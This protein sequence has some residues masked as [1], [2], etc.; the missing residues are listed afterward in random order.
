MIETEIKRNINEIFFSKLF[1]LLITRN[2][3]HRCARRVR[4][5]GIVINRFTALNRAHVL[6]N[7]FDSE[8]LRNR[9]NLKFC[10]QVFSAAIEFHELIYEQRKIDV[11]YPTMTEG[12]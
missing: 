11:L 4:T 3:S 9:K 5:Q 10:V 7:I 12:N 6:V 1:V 8:G 2:C